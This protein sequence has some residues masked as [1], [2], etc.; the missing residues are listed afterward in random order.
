MSLG[1][2]RLIETL[3]PL[4]KLIPTVPRPTVPLP[5][6]SRLTWT[7]LAVT[8]YLLM[9]ITPLY[10]VTR[11]ATFFFDPMIAIVF[12]SSAG[13][14]AHLGI[15]PLVISGII[16]EILVFSRLLDIDV[17]DP[18]DQ[19]RF[20]ALYKLLALLIAL[21][22]SVISVSAHFALAAPYFA[23]LV[24][25]QLLIATTIIILLD[26]L[27][28]K[29]WG[30]GSGISLFILVSIVTTIFWWT[31]G[32]T[33]APDG[34][35]VGIVPA[36]IV[37]VSQGTLGHIVYGYGRPTLVGFVAT[38]VM[39]AIILYVEMLRVPIPLS[40]SRFRGIKYTLPLRVMYV[41]VLP[42]IFTAFSLFFVQQ[43]LYY[44]WSAF[45][46][47]NQN[48]WLNWLVCMKSV[49]GA[50]VPCENTVMHFLSTNPY[51]LTPQYVVAHILIY[52]VLCT[53]YAYVWV[54]LAG[55]SAEDQ[56]RYIV[57]TGLSI[58]GFRSSFKM[59]AAY[60]SKYINALTLTSG[61]LAGL[62][63]SLGNMLHVF[64]GGIGL[65]LLVELTLQ[66]YALAVREHLF[67][68]YPGL[69]RFVESM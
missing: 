29:G 52:V 24:V 68:A 27:I 22:E 6:S 49:G 2:K 18:M 14:L 10:G 25:L 64:A 56:A 1:G 65:I 20:N 9:M 32:P 3:D 63:A 28:S 47:Y 34:L 48:P 11:A 7:F 62:F 44:V 38:I 13:T 31:F 37:S 55:M 51:T 23:P 54:N 19:A 69:K 36:L 40:I 61:V 60:L 26:D 21:F 53:I 43:I 46:P 17:N 58:P 39:T 35:P 67:E 59:V 4:L 41:S 5:L 16:L 50:L 8:V 33:I 30:I 66:Y 12:A 45:N 15:T 42:I 57:Q